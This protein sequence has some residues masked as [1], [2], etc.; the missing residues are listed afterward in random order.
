MDGFKDYEGKNV[1]IKLKNNRSYSGKVLEVEDRG[2]KS[3]III[4]DKFGKRVAFYDTE[5][6]VIEEEAK[7]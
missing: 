3:L 4:I 1:F 2:D 5:I 7:K 6:S